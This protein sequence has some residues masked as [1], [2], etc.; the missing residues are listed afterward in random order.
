MYIYTY[1]YIIYIYTGIINEIYILSK[2]ERG[3]GREKEREKERD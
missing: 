1:K 3:R 2:R